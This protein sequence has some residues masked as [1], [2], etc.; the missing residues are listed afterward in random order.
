[1]PAGNR[2]QVEATRLLPKPD[3]VLSTSNLAAMLGIVRSASVE[4]EAGLIRSM[5]LHFVGL[6]FED[7]LRHAASYT[8]DGR[9]MEAAVLASAV[10]E[11]SVKRLCDKRNSN[12][13]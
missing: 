2:Y 4:W 6:A 7:F 5:E 12:Q 1:M 11:D 3:G 9:I 13:R 10:L 8:E